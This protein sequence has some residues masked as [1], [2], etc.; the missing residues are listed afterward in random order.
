MRDSWFGPRLATGWRKCGLLGSGVLGGTG[1]GQNAWGTTLRVTGSGIVGASWLVGDGGRKNRR[2]FV[3]P[4][5]N[6]VALPVERCG[7]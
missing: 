4:E 3:A 7:G 2:E 5:S 1:P 6:G